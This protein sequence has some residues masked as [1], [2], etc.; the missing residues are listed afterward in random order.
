M[1]SQ[2]DIQI[3]KITE[4]KDEKLFKENVYLK[5]DYL[6][7]I[8]EFHNLTFKKIY[9]N[10]YVNYNNKVREF[11]VLING[12]TPTG[13]QRWVSIE[14]KENDVSKVIEQSL[15]RRDFVD[16]SYCIINNS[17]RWVV[18]YILYVWS[19]YIKE[20]KIGFISAYDNIFVLPSKY[21]K[22]FV[23]YDKPN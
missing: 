18:E 6:N 3:A 21:K 13:R 17:V 23:E 8:S 14:L 16:Y 7:M 19:D 1:T 15:V 22:R 11:D 12:E 20:D 2:T 5:K 10:V 9:K 4:R